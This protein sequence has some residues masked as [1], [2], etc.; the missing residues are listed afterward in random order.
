VNHTLTQPLDIPQHLDTVFH[1]T[2]VI[3]LPFLSLLQIQNTNLEAIAYL[4]VRIQFDVRKG[5][6]VTLF[7]QIYALVFVQ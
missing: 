1:V 6:P 4:H 2:R 7:R 3:A 5:F